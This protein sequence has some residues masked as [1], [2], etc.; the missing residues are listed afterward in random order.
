MEPGNGLGSS[1]VGVNGSLVEPGEVFL[2]I[3]CLVLGEVTASAARN[4][5][6]IGIQAVKQGGIIGIQAVKQGGTDMDQDAKKEPEEGH[7]DE[8]ADVEDVS[9]TDGGK[10]GGSQG[11]H[12]SSDGEIE[13]ADKKKAVEVRADNGPDVA[14][15]GP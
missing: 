3:P 12:E 5:V 14:E 8:L 1:N 2:P 15:D 6:M 7:R 9:K 10:P 11:V 4:C 13:S